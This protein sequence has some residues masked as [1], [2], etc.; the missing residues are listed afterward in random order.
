LKARRQIYTHSVFVGDV[1]LGL[2]TETHLRNT[3]VPTTD[4][5]TDTNLGDKRLA[6]VQGGVELFT[7]GSQLFI[8]TKAPLI[9]WWH[10]VKP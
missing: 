7:V 3:F 8:F 4:D 6:S 1:E 2:L 9:S 10:L 5:L